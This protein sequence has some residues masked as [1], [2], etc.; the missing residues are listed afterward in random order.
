MRSLMLFHC[1]L[2]LEIC[3]TATTGLEIFIHTWKPQKE[4]RSVHEVDSPDAGAEGSSGGDNN[5]NTTSDD[6]EDAAWWDEMKQK[7]QRMRQRQSERMRE[8]SSST[9]ALLTSLENIEA[10]TGLE[11][12]QAGDAPGAPPAITASGW[13]V[14]V[15][16]ALAPLWL[17][18]QLSSALQAA[19]HLASGSETSSLL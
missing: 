1:M 16:A 13:F 8:V 10:V 7:K 6:D 3:D 14:V 4:Q 2:E 19:L 11:L 15:A 17:A 12:T 9:S 18:W 5:S